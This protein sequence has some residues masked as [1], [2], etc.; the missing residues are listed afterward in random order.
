MAIEPHTAGEGERNRAIA[1][2]PGT[3][4]LAERDA[5]TTTSA[6]AVDREH[7]QQT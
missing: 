6:T 2:R 7:L 5:E 4:L 3:D 1:C